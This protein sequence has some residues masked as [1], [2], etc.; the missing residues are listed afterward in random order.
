MHVH[1]HM[2]VYTCIVPLLMACVDHRWTYETAQPSECWI[3]MASRSSTSTPLSSSVSIW[4]T[5]SYSRCDVLS[6]LTPKFT[7]T[8]TH[9]HTHALSLSLSS[10]ICQIFI[11]KT[12]KSEQDEYAREGIQWEPVKYFNNKVVCDLIEKYPRCIMGFLD[13]VT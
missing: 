7:N 13:E 2:C 12:L 6:P 3:S 11:E 10:R 1:V 8:Y 9:T 5:R 4:S